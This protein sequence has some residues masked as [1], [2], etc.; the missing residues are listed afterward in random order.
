MNVRGVPQDK[1]IYSHKGA[2]INAEEQ[3]SVAGGQWSVGCFLLLTIESTTIDGRLSA[4]AQ[5]A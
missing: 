3:W 4:C 5:S 2:R 1:P